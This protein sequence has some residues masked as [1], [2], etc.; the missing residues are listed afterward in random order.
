MLVA[1]LIT[2]LP[3]WKALVDSVATALLV[4]MDW[5]VS[6]VAMLKN[7]G[8]ATAKR[9]KKEVVV[10][11]AI[12]VLHMTALEVPEGCDPCPKHVSAFPESIAIDKFRVRVTNDCIGARL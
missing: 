12:D 3:A 5:L 8:D 7:D 6:Q 10:F 4:V 2:L 9:F 11:N 1:D